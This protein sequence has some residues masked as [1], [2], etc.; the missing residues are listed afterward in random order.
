MEWYRIPNIECFIFVLS[1][2]VIVDFSKFYNV[3]TDKYVYFQASQEYAFAYELIE[4]NK[5]GVTFNPENKESIKNAIHE[6]TANFHFYK[7]NVDQFDF[8][9]KDLEQLNSYL[10]LW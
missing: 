3:Y 8:N 7:K 1:S 4:E 5:T 2:I 9:K 10:R 6:I